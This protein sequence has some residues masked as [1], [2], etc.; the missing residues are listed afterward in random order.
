MDTWIRAEPV[1]HHLEFNIILFS[2][3]KYP[4]EYYSI[5]KD[6]KLNQGPMALCFFCI[7]TSETL[8]KNREKNVEV[9]SR[10]HQAPDA[11][12]SPQKASGTGPAMGRKQGEV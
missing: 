11:Q 5:L 3:I 1:G 9:P 10:G 4:L 2:A 7:N 6:L 12:P 8:P